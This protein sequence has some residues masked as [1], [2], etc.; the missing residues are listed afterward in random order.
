M[1][2][3][4][5]VTLF[6]YYKED[7]GASIRQQEEVELGPYKGMGFLK[8]NKDMITI[9]DEGTP[10]DTY[11]Y[12]PASEFKANALP[13]REAIM[14]LIADIEVELKEIALIHYAQLRVERDATIISGVYEE[15]TDLYEQW[16]EVAGPT[17]EINK[18]K[19]RF[20]FTDQQLQDYYCRRYWL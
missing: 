11:W 2:K 10:E 18:L 5:I 20:G 6:D 14:D 4:D 19:M 16:D 8:I 12:V 17:F 1:T 9:M 7:E 15:N 13:H 3:E